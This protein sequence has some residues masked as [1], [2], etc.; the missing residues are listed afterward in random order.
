MPPK[1]KM[2]APIDRPLSRAYLREFSGWSTAYPP[3]LSDPTSLRI[4]ENVMI[5]RD[6]SC[7]VRPGMRYLSYVDTGFT[8]FD[9]QVVGTHEP[10]FLNDGKRAYL[11]ACREDDDTVGFRVLVND[12]SLNPIYMVKDLDDPIV[13]FTLPAVPADLNF[14]ED[15]TYVK[16]LQIDNKILALSNAGESVRIFEVGATK[17]AKVPQSIDRPNWDVADKPIVWHPSDA[18][19]PLPGEGPDVGDIATPT[20]NTLV[21]SNTAANVYNFGY[22]YTFS[23]ELGESAASQVTVIKTQRPW[24]GWR[25]ETS[26]GAAEPSGT[27]TSDPEN[28]A[29]RIAIYVAY[30]AYAAA[31]AAGATAWNLYMMTWSDQDAVPPEAILLYTTPIHS[32]TQWEDSGWARHS[33]MTGDFDITAQ[34]PNVTNR[35]NYSD[36]SKASQGI[37]AADRLVLVGDPTAPA[38]I[39]WSS[40]QQGDYLNFTASKGGGYKTL[41]SGN[42]YTTAAVKLWQNPQSADTLTILNQGVDGMSNS[43][44]MAPADVT[45]QSDVTPIMGFEETTATPGTTSPYGCEIFNN[46]L[47][48]PIDEQ[49]MKSTASNYNINHK[50]QT[51]QIANRWMA[52]T[53]KH[54]IVSSQHDGRL[55]YIVHNPFGAELEEGCMGNEI[56]VL[57]AVA[58]GGNWSR[59]LIQAC[60]LRRIEVAGQIYMSVVRP[61]GIFC[62][63]PELT[64]DDTVVPVGLAVDPANITWRLETNTQGANR[65]H[66]AW[67]HLQQVGIVLGNFQGSMRYG[68][69]GWDHHGQP[70]NVSKVIHDINPPDTENDLPFDLEDQLLVQRGMKEWH[71][72]AESIEMDEVP[73]E[74]VGQISLVQYRYA[75]L[76]VN[77]GYEYGSV[78][79]FEYARATESWT[80]RTTDSGVPIPF[81]DARRP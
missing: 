33:P 11:F 80:E 17:V 67:A 58:E 75:P 28:T 56:W 52:L 63:D 35:Y 30:P 59:W 79:S 65:A 51:E 27:T 47:Y 24:S 64:H 68:V 50:T 21:S 48:H 14:T 76:S 9:K 61:D 18:W 57:D 37:V 78:E 54:R 74:G 12:P 62:L 39:R 1:A 22:F 71:F 81:N 69:K 40:N 66:D 32:A 6:G 34:V 77:I 31:E 5:N 38:V 60:A 70:V 53:N 29:D 23:N 49:L 13:G 7:S 25:W 20:A 36:P 43:Y 41:T 42:L 16:Y 15:T 72:Y 45:S 10:F 46:A 3:G 2:P 26:N 8:A 73:Q 55:Y 44:Y 19:P 4:M